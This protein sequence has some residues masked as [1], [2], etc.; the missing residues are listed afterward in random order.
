MEEKRVVAEELDRGLPQW[1]NL[2]AELRPA[3][4]NTARIWLALWLRCGLRAATTNPSVFLW[5]SF[6]GATEQ[7]SFQPWRQKDEY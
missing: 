2:P 6:C 5:P 7:I 1:K 3:L 4:D